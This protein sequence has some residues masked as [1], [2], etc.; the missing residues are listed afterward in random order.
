MQNILDFRMRIHLV[1]PLVC[2]RKAIAPLTFRD[3]IKIW[4]TSCAMTFKQ[5]VALKPVPALQ[6]ARRMM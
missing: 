4:G 1:R 2:G 3:L 6:L 5:C